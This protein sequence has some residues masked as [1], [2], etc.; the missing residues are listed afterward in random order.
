MAS[1]AGDVAT[2]D[3]RPYLLSFNGTD[4]VAPADAHCVLIQSDVW[5]CSFLKKEYTSGV[6]SET[7]AAYGGERPDTTT[8][9]GE[10]K[11][12]SPY[13]TEENSTQYPADEV[14]VLYPGAGILTPSRLRNLNANPIEKVSTPRPIDKVLTNYPTEGDYP[15]ED[16]VA[17]Y[18]SEEAPAEYPMEEQYQ[19]E[20]V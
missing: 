16:V 15:T 14:S 17:E 9:N 6:D 3:C 12:L 11:E 10:E 18:P 8:D 2:A 13:L 20:E 1:K 7:T 4:C 5:G 19:T